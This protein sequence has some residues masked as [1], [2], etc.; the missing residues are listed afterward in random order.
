MIGVAGQS[1]AVD[2]KLTARENLNLFGRLYKIPRAERQRRTEELIER[3]DLDDFADRP[4]STYSGG[5]RRRLD[6]VAALVA[7]P[8]AVFLDEPTTGLDL[9]SRTELWDTVRSLATEGTAIVLSTQYLEEADRLADKIL[10]I[11]HGEIVAQ[12]SPDELKANLDRNVLEIH[13]ELESGVGDAQ[14]LLASEE[15]V[16]A[17]VEARRI[18]IHVGN[19]ADRSLALLRRLQD[20]GIS[21]Q[22][23]Q[24]REPTLD[25]VFLS[26]TGSPATET[27]ELTE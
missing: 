16:V 21:I 13:L 11:D 6:V 25:D 24:L 1:A 22:N 12:G 18:D 14:E 23:F 5:E 4:A 26:L 10:V 9:R 15:N 27:E 7:N 17:D 8:P 3:F 2:E 20:G 19:D